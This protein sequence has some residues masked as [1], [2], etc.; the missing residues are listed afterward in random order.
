M[1][2]TRLLDWMLNVLDRKEVAHRHN[3]LW[4]MAPRRSG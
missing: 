1:A 4:P 3:G 2:A